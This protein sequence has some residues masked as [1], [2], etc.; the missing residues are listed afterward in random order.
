MAF[1]CR[2]AIDYHYTIWALWYHSIALSRLFTSFSFT[3]F[4]SRTRSCHHTY[5]QFVSEA[6]GDSIS[7]M[8]LYLTPIHHKYINCLSSESQNRQQSTMIT[9]QYR[10]GSI[11]RKSQPMLT[12]IVRRFLGRQRITILL[13]GF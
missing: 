10:Y 6:S 7:G 1:T 11:G 5:F 2:M 8:A 4:S 9:S 13:N 12:V 3:V